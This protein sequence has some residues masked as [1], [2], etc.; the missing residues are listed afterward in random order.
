MSDLR[1]LNIYSDLYY[2]T[3]YY[4]SEHALIMTLKHAKFFKHPIC[5]VTDVHSFG[6]L[7]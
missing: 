6:I 7:Y 4:S 3:R 1:I 2:C 5:D